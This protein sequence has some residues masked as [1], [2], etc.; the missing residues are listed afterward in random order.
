L[1]MSDMVM[2]GPG[3]VTKTT[4]QSPSRA[5]DC[6]AANGNMLSIDSTVI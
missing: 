1:P 2:T 3:I 4:L 5:V 6:A